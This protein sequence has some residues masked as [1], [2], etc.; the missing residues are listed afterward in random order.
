MEDIGETNKQKFE[1]YLRNSKNVP[2]VIKFS[3]LLPL[4]VYSQIS[5]EWGCLSQW[6]EAIGNCKVN[7]ITIL[8]NLMEQIVFILQ[9][10]TLKKKDENRN[11]SI[12]MKI[13]EYIDLFEE[14]EDFISK[15]VKDPTHENARFED[16]D[17]SYIPYCQDIN[18]NDP[19][20]SNLHS[21]LFDSILPHLPFLEKE[22]PSRFLFL[23]PKGSSTPIH[24]DGCGTHGFLML[25]CG[26]KRVQLWSFE[27]S[28]LGISRLCQEDS[29]TVELKEMEILY[30]PSGMAHQVLNVSKCVAI[31]YVYKCP[32]CF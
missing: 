21:K 29:A 6:K 8:F 19:Q 10:V 31:Q 11:T 27:Q 28:Y 9:K 14:I 2:F 7:G 26:E 17:L 15:K 32:N 13:R 18:L 30:I 25:F 4:P 24:V 1:G 3:S 16:L 20:F 23:G 5:K 22:A 12:L